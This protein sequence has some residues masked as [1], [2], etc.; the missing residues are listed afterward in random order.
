M[1]CPWKGSIL[2]YMSPFRPSGDK[3]KD[4]FSVRYPFNSVCGKWDK[5]EE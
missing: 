4:D 2:D 3:E 1:K 5:E